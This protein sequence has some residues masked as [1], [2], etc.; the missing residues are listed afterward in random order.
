LTAQIGHLLNALLLAAQNF[1]SLGVAASPVFHSLLDGLT[2]HPMQ[3]PGFAATS[4]E[5]QRQGR[6]AVT[7]AATELLQVVVMSVEVV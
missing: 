5:Q 1:L 4:A 2:S 3:Q 7:A 6:L